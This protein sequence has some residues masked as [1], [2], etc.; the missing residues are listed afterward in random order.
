ME[1]EGIAMTAKRQ[2]VAG[3]CRCGIV[4]LILLRGALSDQ[5]GTSAIETAPGQARIVPSLR[6][7]QASV[8][9]DDSQRRADRVSFPDVPTLVPAQNDADDPSTVRDG[10]SRGAPRHVRPGGRLPLP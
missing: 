10:R 4:A 5:P 1:P 7:D 8:S 3:S 6:R 2:L 9:R